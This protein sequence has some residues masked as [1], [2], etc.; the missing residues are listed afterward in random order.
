MDFGKQQIPE[1]TKRCSITTISAQNDITFEAIT[2]EAI[3]FEAITF[4]ATISALNS[5]TFEAITF[6]DTKH[7]R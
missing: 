7:G 4:E 5:I 6:E 3:T 1:Q 2:F